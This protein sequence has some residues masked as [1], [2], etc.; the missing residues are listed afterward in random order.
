MQ[1]KKTP[2]GKLLIEGAQVMRGSFR[3]FSGEKEGRYDQPGKRYFNITIDDPIIA[4]L[5]SGDHWPIKILPPRDEYDKPQNIMKV[6][7][8]PEN[9]YFPCHVRTICN[10]VLTSLDP[11]TYKLLDGADIVSGDLT[12][13]LWEYNPGEFS[14]QLEEGIFNIQPLSYWEDKYAQEEH[15]WE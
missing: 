15:P 9:R 12:L 11:E 6:T 8:K 2:D 1:T 5:M 10:G 13:R 4:Q 7:V 14:A 3:N